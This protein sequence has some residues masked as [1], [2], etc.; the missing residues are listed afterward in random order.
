MLVRAPQHP[1]W[2]MGQV[3]SVIGDRVTVSFVEIGRAV[4]DM[5]YA[6]LDWVGDGS[7]PVERR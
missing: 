6:E 2:G 7:P 3:Q 4:L 5:R 1:E